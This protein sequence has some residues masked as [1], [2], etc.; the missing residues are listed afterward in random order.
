MKKRDLIEAW[1]KTTRE[2]VM[3]SDRIQEIRDT[4]TKG[5]YCE[6]CCDRRFLLS[7]IDTMRAEILKNGMTFIKLHEKNQLLQAV[8]DAV[9]NISEH[10]EG[11]GGE[12]TMSGM[13]AVDSAMT[14]LREF[15]KGVKC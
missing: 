13:D 14:A 1:E 5:C 4:I 9:E 11:Y 6:E 10:C 7:E 15:E 8:A 12:V 3:M 2:G